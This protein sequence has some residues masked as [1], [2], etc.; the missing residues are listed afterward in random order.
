VLKAGFAPR[1]DHA[2]IA[3]YRLDFAGFPRTGAAIAVRETSQ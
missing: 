2:R 1:L 3:P